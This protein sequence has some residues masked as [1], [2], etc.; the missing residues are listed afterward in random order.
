MTI[1]IS[2]FNNSRVVLSGNF[3]YENRRPKRELCA[4]LLEQNDVKQAGSGP[5]RLVPRSEL[6]GMKENRRS[7]A[8]KYEC[9][10]NAARREMMHTGT[11]IF[12]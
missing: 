1:R 6:A 7:L 5:V 4:G 9:F 2:I 11:A 3:T 12:K 10:G 8:A